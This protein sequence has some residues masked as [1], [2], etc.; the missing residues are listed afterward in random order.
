MRLHLV[1]VTIH[2]VVNGHLVGQRLAIMTMNVPVGRVETIMIYN[3]RAYCACSVPIMRDAVAHESYCSCKSFSDDH[4][5]HAHYRARCF[6]HSWNVHPACCVNKTRP[7]NFCRD[8][9]WMCASCNDREIISRIIVNVDQNF[10]HRVKDIHLSY[11]DVTAPQRWIYY[12]I[13]LPRRVY[14]W[15]HTT[16]SLSRETL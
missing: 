8:N 4:T 2:H 10:L 1:R 14:L 9:R 12:G 11:G 15:R 16:T 13:T 5:Q 6:I 3:L 7:K